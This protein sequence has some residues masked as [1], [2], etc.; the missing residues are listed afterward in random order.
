MSDSDG[1][2]VKICG[3]TEPAT[4]ATAAQ[5]GARYVGFVFYP[6]SPRY[7]HLDRA[8]ALSAAVPANVSKVALTVDA[9]NAMLDA[10]LEQVSIDMLQLQGAETPDRIAEV[11][12][13]FGLPVMKAVGVGD[14]ADLA[15]LDVY[16][17]VADQ[18]LVDAKP[19]KVG[20][21]PGGNGVP[22]DWSLLQG[23]RWQTPWLLAG[24]LTSANVAEAIRLTGTQQ[25]D[26]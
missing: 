4:L 22:F 3:L 11:K 16:E 8:A 2:G 18:V 9:D 15:A 12:R 6:P 1:I 25:V 5:A 17:G 14:P 20:G 19:P 13:R 10:L 24:G 7:L 21:V 23:R 26:V